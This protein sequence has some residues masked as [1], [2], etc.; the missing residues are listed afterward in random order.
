VTA[1]RLQRLNTDLLAVPQ[2]FTIH[3]KLARQLERRAS[4]L[5]PVAGEIDWA[6]GE[7]LALA[8][9]VTDGRPVRMTGQDTERGTFSHRHLVLHDAKTGETWMPLQH[10]SKAKASFELYN[11]PLSEY[12]CVAFEYG[13]SAA[14]ADALI[15]WEAQF[16]DFA[17]GAQIII[18]QFISG[19]FAKWGATSRLTLLLPHGY[20]GAGPEHSSARL[21]RFLQLAAEGNF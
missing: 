12:A 4:A 10:L 14:A 13:Y 18:D 17:N 11:S 6:L 9:L 2:G 19:G 20:E 8:S 7:A 3:P 21:E 16:G 1:E 5:D 15:L